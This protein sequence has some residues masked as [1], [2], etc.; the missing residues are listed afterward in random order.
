MR[1]R[2]YSRGWQ[3]HTAQGLGLSPRT[4]RHWERLADE[5]CPSLRYRGRR[6]ARMDNTTRKAL[7]SHLRETGPRVSVRDL[8]TVFPHAARRE[9]AD[10]LRRYRYWARRT[11]IH[12][13]HWTNI[14]AVW[15]IDFTEAPSPIDG[16]H[17]YIL[18]VRDL[19]SGRQLLSLPTRDQTAQTVSDAIMSLFAQHSPPLVLKSDNGGGFKARDVRAL[20]E[21]NG[22][23]LLA[24]PPH[25]PSYNGACE[26][27]IGSVKCRCHEIACAH[28][29]P[30]QWSANDVEAARLQ[31]NAISRPHGNDQP[32][33]DEAWQIRQPIHPREREAFARDVAR[34]MLEVKHAW[35]YTPNEDL[36][37]ASRDRVDREAIRRVLVARGYLVIRRRRITLPLRN[38]KTAK[39]S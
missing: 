26:A 25:T 38:L 16:D 15:A 18:A 21:K 9:L 30:S 32:T 23:H 2:P 10:V 5:E 35:G 19:A 37:P 7:L 1:R 17:P 28:G 31:A 39:N 14:G 6:P 36:D 22:A 24:S 3:R 34:T 12:R 11:E 33:P 20:L 13:L 8:R 29:A 4:L 27:G